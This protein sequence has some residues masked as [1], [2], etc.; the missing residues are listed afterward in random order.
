MSPAII[1]RTIQRPDLLPCVSR[2][3]C[4]D[5][6]VFPYL[7]LS[8]ADDRRVIMIRHVLGLGVGEEHRGDKRAL[9]LG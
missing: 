9:S 2:V 4:H 6:P 8:D 7:S 1:S 3:F 5:C